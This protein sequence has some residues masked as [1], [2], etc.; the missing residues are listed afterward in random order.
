VSDRRLQGCEI[1]TTEVSSG[2]GVQV[3]L[4]INRSFDVGP[5]SR[6]AEHPVLKVK[7]SHERPAVECPVTVAAVNEAAG[8]E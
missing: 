1:R 8:R 2:S 5:R 4:A 3:Q 6:N 7:R